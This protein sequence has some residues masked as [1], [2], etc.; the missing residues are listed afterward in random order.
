LGR[1]Y[2]LPTLN[3][4]FE[5]FFRGD[6]P[7]EGWAPLCE[8][9]D[10]EISSDPL[11]NINDFADFRNRCR[12]RNHLQIMNVLLQL[13]TMGGSLLITGL[14]ATMGFKNFTRPSC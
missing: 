12:T 9:L 2:V 10:E 13:I 14:A 8:F 6:F 1:G 5:I 4:F 11:P 3:K 7:N